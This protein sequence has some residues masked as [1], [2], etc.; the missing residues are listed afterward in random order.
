MGKSRKHSQKGSPGC[1]G[2]GRPKCVAPNRGRA[3]PAG[4]DR[5]CCHA[6]RCSH[7]HSSRAPALQVLHPVPK[8]GLRASN[9]PGLVSVGGCLRDFRPVGAWAR[10]LPSHTPSHGDPLVNADAQVWSCAVAHGQLLVQSVALGT[11]VE[12][13]RWKEELRG[14]FWLAGL[15]LFSSMFV[16][17]CL[18]LT[19]HWEGGRA[20][21]PVTC[22]GAPT[23]LLHA[24][25]SSPMPLCTHA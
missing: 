17:C 2:L 19:L 7:R 13:A 24:G 21:R 18:P 16:A 25:P 9:R 5:C 11:P 23:P 15:G 20:T 14:P 1:N 4:G 10:R 8:A 6:G 12:P 22:T 3:G